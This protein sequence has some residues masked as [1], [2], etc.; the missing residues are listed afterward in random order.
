ME[1][2]QDMARKEGEKP[3][4]SEHALRL[5]GRLTE[6]HGASGSEGA[7]RRIFREE[8]GLGGSSGGR[9]EPGE[10]AREVRADGLGS[11][12]FER[13]GG[14]DK[15]RIM[16]TA[17]MDEVGFM[18]QTITSSGRIKFVPLGGWWAHTLPAMRV[19]ILTRSGREIIGV[20]GAKPAHFL[21]D[22][23]REKLQKI[24][25]MFIDVGAFSAEEV[26]E[27]FGIELGDTIVPESSF[28]PMHNPELLLGK[29]FDNRVGMA[30]LIQTMQ[31]LEPQEHPNALWAVGTVQEEVGVRGAHTAAHVVRPDAAIVLEGAPADDLPGVPTD[32]VQGALGNGAQIRIMDPSAIMN[33]KFVRLAIDT[34]ERNGIRHQV[35]VRRSGGTDARAIQS[36]G[37]GV[38]TIV[39]SVPAR[40]I[41]T[42]SCIIHLKDYLDALSLVSCL[43]RK[44]DAATVAGFGNMDD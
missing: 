34:A 27:R 18:V 13:K 20:I 23:E 7:V 8:L 1:E 10:P 12:I 40:Y 14:A 9:G 3:S 22:A 43:L 15:P 17:H 30:L 44:L 11:I 6:A 38:P 42:Q 41:H 26:R 36:H 37:S 28:T 33:R 2:I 35:T 5:L 32:E 39:L 4:D 19:R 25:D 31:T 24:D 21:T 16:L 29:A